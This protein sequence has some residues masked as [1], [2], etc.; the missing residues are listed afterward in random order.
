[1]KVEINGLCDLRPEKAE[2]AKRYLRKPTIILRYIRVRLKS[3]RLFCDRQDIDLIYIYTMAFVHT[4]G[5]LCHESG[6]HVAVEV[7][8]AKTI[9]EC[10]ELVETSR[11]KKKH[12]M[13]L[14]NCCY[15]FF[16]LLTLNMARQGFLGKSYMEKGHTFIISSI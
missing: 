15:D 5:S 8:A 6:K 13:M 2:E 3:G 4:N 10:W 16:E 1:M 7:P 11:K 9:E 12:C 14:E